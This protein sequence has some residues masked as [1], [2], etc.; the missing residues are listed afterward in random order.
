MARDVLAALPKTWEQ[1]P[2]GR[3]GVRT[4]MLQVGSEVGQGLELQFGA[5]NLEALGIGDL[6]LADGL[7]RSAP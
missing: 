7:R 3:G 5:M 4:A 6:T 2:Q 1:I